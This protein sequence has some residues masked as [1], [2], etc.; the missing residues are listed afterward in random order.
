MDITQLANPPCVFLKREPIAMIRN[1]I[2][3]PDMT[4]INAIGIN[5]IRKITICLIDLTSIDTA[6]DAIAN[7]ER[8]KN[9]L[10]SKIAKEFLRILIDI[11]AYS[12]CI[13]ITEK[14]SK[15]KTTKGIDLPVM[16]I[17]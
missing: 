8:Y 9:N 3:D 14:I 2:I 7:F 12:L 10:K 4:I 5:E 15:I 16:Y 17:S 1:P 6:K 11:I 13:F